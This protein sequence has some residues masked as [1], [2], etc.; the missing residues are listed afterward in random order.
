AWA[1]EARSSFLAGYRAAR[2]DLE[3]TVLRAL[4]LDKALYEAVY[5]QKNR[6]DWLPIPLGGV[7]RLTEEQTVAENSPPDGERLL[8][9]IF[10]TPGPRPGEPARPT[11]AAPSPAAQGVPENATQAAPSPDGARPAP[12]PQSVLQAV[13]DGSHFAPHD[14]LGPHLDTDTG[15]LTIRVVAHLATAVTVLT[16]AGEHPAQHTRSEE[17]RV[18]KERI[19]P[20]E[21]P[22]AQEHTAAR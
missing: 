21:P 8:A 1:E 13:A 18:G 10:P 9:G 2:G 22:A 14:V 5:E 20:R 15:V 12:V 11:Q 4:E 19:E 3:E 7:R 17:R 6:P 16:S